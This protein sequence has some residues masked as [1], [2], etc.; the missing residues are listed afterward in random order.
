MKYKLYLLTILMTI[1]SCGTL[2]SQSINKS[3]LDSLLNILSVN[4]KAMGSLTISKN[5]RIQYSRAIGY[6]YISDKNKDLST[7]K[8]KYRIGSISKMFTASMI[9]QLI[10]EGK[11]KL[12]TTIDEFF[13]KLPNS[14]K[15]TIGN[16]LNHHS[17]LH[18]FTDDSNYTN[19]MTEP[20]THDDMLAYISRNEVD[21]QPNE[22]GAYSNSNYVVLGYIIENVTKQ[23]YSKNLNERITSKIGLKDTYIGGKS[24]IKN[25]ESFSYRW[26]NNWEQQPQ[27]DMSIP[28]GA[29]AIVSTPT[30]LTK[31]IEALFSLKLI[32][33]NSLN[34]MKT[35]T[36][37]YGMGMFQF[38]F[39]TKK[40]YGH[41]GGI[42]GFNSNLAYF[43]E[44]SL[45][46]SYCTNGAVYPVNDILIGVLSIYFNQDYTF[47]SFNTISF[48]AEDLDKYK[49]VYSSLQIPLKITISKENTSLIAQ[50]HGQSPFPLEASGK[51]KFSFDQA[52]IIIEF[53]TKDNQF[54]L[55]QGGGKYLFTKEK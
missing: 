13:P 46:V 53:N 51:D 6:S 12:T 26:N 55:F 52:G 3:K 28:G 37:G 25:N 41:T 42:D 50:A 2:V 36:D 45:A 35:I 18:N 30:D 38:P 16:L 49:G 34:Q 1:M 44:D 7:I 11:I 33:Q 22:K 48:K 39:N 40:A 31:F 14:K 21:F 8:T 32:S 4:N 9:F 27:T 29:G 47:P 10:E 17:G 20:K 43:P 54:T 5:G 23:S 15:I 24:N 19:W